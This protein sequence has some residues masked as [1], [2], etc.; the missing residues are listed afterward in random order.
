MFLGE[1][2]RIIL[3]ILASFRLTWTMIYEDGPFD[4]IMRLRTALGAYDL[5]ENGEPETGIGRFLTC[6]YCVSRF[7]ALFAI[8]IVLWPTL[9]GDLFIIWYGIA[10][11]LALLIRWRPWNNY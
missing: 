1:T 5:G 2:E 10:G 11:A 8:P 4:A 9:I 7:V 3:A 6:S